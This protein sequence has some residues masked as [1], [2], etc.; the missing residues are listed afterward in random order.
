MTPQSATLAWRSFL[1]VLRGRRSRRF[2]LGMRMESGPLAYA[3]RQA[4][5]PLTEEEEALLVFAACG[6]TGRALA[7]LVYEKGEGGTIMAGLT[8]RTI[9][10]GDG[11]QT[12]ALIVGNRDA[13]YYVR[14]PQDFAP[15]AVTELIGLAEREQYVELYRRMRVRIGAGLDPP[16]VEPFVNIDCNRW[17]LYDGAATYFLPVV[18]FTVLYINGLLEVFGVR[19]GGMY[20]LDERAWFRPAGVKRF[21]R[22]RGGELE[23]D[24]RKDRALTIQQLETLVTE[25]ATVEAGMMIQNIALMTHALGLGG[26]P[27]WAAHPYGWFRSLGFRM[28]T[29]NASRYLGMSFVLRFV[30]TLFGRD[31]PV[32]YVTG[33]EVDGVPLLAPHCPPNFPT[34]EDAVR[35][36]VDMKWGPSGIFRAGARQGAWSDSGAIADAAPGVGEAAVNATIAYCEYVYRRYGRFPAYQ[37]PLR[38]LLGFQANHV[39]VEFYDRFYRPDALTELQREHLGHWHGDD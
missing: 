18:D 26:F 33:L 22:S 6:I 10:S 20:V 38:T 34:M 35:H 19:D 5:L 15:D 27:H 13:T 4:G 31:R 16:P 29:V 9:P 21:A 39:D 1:D 8:G 23:D 30:A 7:D 3:S 28:S 36:V 37:A 14:R 2:G 11:I 24:L 25:F 32:P 12:C 17:S